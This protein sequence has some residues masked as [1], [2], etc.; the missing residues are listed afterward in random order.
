MIEHSAI[1]AAI[2][3]IPHSWLLER[4][5][6]GAK[7]RAVAAVETLD[8]G[9]LP[10][11]DAAIVALVR[12]S[13]AGGGADS[14]MLPL[15][16]SSHTHLPEA[17]APAAVELEHDGQRMY[18]HDALASA[19]VRD[20]LLRLMLDRAE[21]PLRNG[22]L[23]FRPEPEL[24]DSAPPASRSRLLSVEQSNSSLVYD[25]RAFMKLFRRVV[26]GL[27]PD[28]EVGRFLKRA[29]FEQAPVVLGDAVYVRDGQEYSLALLQAWVPNDGAAWDRTLDRLAAFYAAVAADGRQDPDELE[30]RTAEQ[31]RAEFA[32]FAQLGRLTGELHLALASDSHDPA[33]APRTITAAATAAW[34][35]SIRE[36]RRAMLPQ[37]AVRGPE[38]PADQRAIVERLLA[39]DARIEAGIAALDGLAA[40]GLT[41]TRFHGDYHLGQILVAEHGYL[42]I[43]FEGEPMRSLAERR[44][45]GS[46]LKDV[47]G[48]LRSLSYAASAGLFAARAATPAPGLAQYASAWEQQA[49]RWFLESYWNTVR[50]AS[51]VPPDE[52][53]RDGALRAFEL[54]KALYELGYELNNRPDWLPI[55]LRGIAGAIG[56]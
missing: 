5:W 34:K 25:D 13:Y 56:E 6:F 43:D 2:A 53:V 11:P 27:N 50:G 41:A 48:M 44:A 30:R 20:A 21:L 10:G 9:A 4:R 19:P 45:H 3:R 32:A 29:G 49:R 54:E 31:G 18:V 26:P 28:V 12:V 24:L 23:V 17:S 36:L 16:A 51:F 37:L 35:A 52:R 42:V 39:S 40:A 46:P 1:A 22:Q 38:L 14:Y 8:W 47:A 7:G 55:P 15:L 33:F